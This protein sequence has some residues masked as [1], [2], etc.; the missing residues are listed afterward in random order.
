MEVKRA[1]WVL[2]GSRIVLHGVCLGLLLA[3]SFGEQTL[4]RVRAQRREPHPSLILT[5]VGDGSP[6]VLHWLE[7]M[8]P[9]CSADVRVQAWPRVVP[10]PSPQLL[11]GE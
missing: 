11:G 10:D 5:T 7:N 2:L 4:R 9:E 6:T 1:Q 3:Q 8:W